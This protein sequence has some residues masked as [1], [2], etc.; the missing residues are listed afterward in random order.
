[1]FFSRS[2]SAREP[3]DIDSRIAIGL[4]RFVVSVGPVQV[5]VVTYQLRDLDRAGDQR[6]VA[7]LAME[8]IGPPGVED[9]YLVRTD[10]AGARRTG[11]EGAPAA[12][13]AAYLLERL[14]A[15]GLEIADLG[16]LPSVCY[17]PDPEHPRRQ[18]LPLVVG[19]A[20]QVADRVDRALAS[21]RLPLVL[22]GDCSLSLGVL[23]GLLRHHSRLGLL[24]F[25]GDVDLNTPETT[26][27]GVFD[28]MVMAHALGRGV[29]QLAGIGPRR[30][31]LEEEDVVLFGYDETSG[32]IDPA[33]LEAL[34]SS[35][36]SKY[37]LARV[38]ADAAAAAGDAL[39]HLES[40]SEAFL[41]HFDVDVMDLPAVDVFH[42]HGLDAGSAFAALKVFAAAPACAAVV[43]TELNVERDPDGSHTRSLVDG[44][45]EALGAR[46][47]SAG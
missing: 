1:M 23:A 34:E 31:L 33:E 44:L 39:A 12:L 36:M 47:D 4:V 46:E 27:S 11:Q 13:R 5:S 43:V 8:L 16:D 45:V 38:R 6:L 17:R 19:V 3:L 42:P 9:V 24:Y 32:W 26:P 22:G 2:G 28:G 21:R 7:P 41:L 35:R 29:R 15:G 25:D 37:P 30:P 20:R 14:W 10:R 18:N 40:R